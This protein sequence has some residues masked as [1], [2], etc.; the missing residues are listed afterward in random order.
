MGDCSVGSSA[1]TE[2]NDPVV[3]SNSADGSSTATATWSATGGFKFTGV[4]TA[5][6]SANAAGNPLPGSTSQFWG[7]TAGA[8]SFAS[9]ALVINISSTDAFAWTFACTPSSPV[10]GYTPCG[11]G[12][13]GSYTISPGVNGGVLASGTIVNGSGAMTFGVTAEF[14]FASVA[15]GGNVPAAASSGLESVSYTLTLVPVPEP[16][17]RLLMLAGL[18]A[19]GVL[20]PGARKRR[21]SG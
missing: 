14:S 4:V 15:T 5:S 11:F 9:E 12:P 16:S 19:I 3:G 1:I 20:I 17:A 18:S 10:G 8:G 7:V 13:I 6:V 21:S 2:G